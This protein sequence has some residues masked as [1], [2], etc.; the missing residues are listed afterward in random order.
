MYIYT[1]IYTYTH[2]DKFKYRLLVLLATLFTIFVIKERFST[3]YNVCKEVY[4]MR[5]IKIRDKLGKMSY[6]NA[7]ISRQF[8]IFIYKFIVCMSLCIYGYL[9]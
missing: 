4:W 5:S 7:S 3:T 1:H 6:S 2:T 9:I 8:Y